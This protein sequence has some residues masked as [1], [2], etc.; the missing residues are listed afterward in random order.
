MWRRLLLPA[1]QRAWCDHAVVGMAPTESSPLRQQLVAVSERLDVVLASVRGLENAELLATLNCPTFSQSLSA[2][3]LEL[4]PLM[5]LPSLPGKVDCFGDGA[6][7]FLTGYTQHLLGRPKAALSCCTAALAAWTEAPA[8]WHYLSAQVA[9]AADNTELAEQC[10]RG[11]IDRDPAH[12]A[13]HLELMGLLA[14]K[15]DFRGC[16]A[17]AGSAAAQTP[18]LHWSSEWQ[19]PDHMMPGLRATPW[20][21]P[22]SFPWVKML[23]ANADVIRSEL[24]TVV[25]AQQAHQRGGKASGGAA[26]AAGQQAPG[27]VPVGHHCVGTDHTL[28]SEGGSWRELVLAGEE[29]EDG[30]VAA[31]N[32]R[33]FPRTTA[34]LAG[35]PAVAGL[36]E[37]GLGEALFSSLAPGSKLKPHCGGSNL[38]LTCHLTLVLGSGESGIICGGEKR[39]WEQGKCLVFDDSFEHAVYHNEPEPAAVAAAEAADHPCNGERVVLLLRFWHPGEPFPSFVL[40]PLTRWHASL[41]RTLSPAAAAPT[42]DTRA[43]A[44]T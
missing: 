34:L 32:R 18:K 24:L 4:Q 40:L 39:T 41:A 37:A 14:D 35:I 17:L 5:G 11:A 3:E 10:L 1:V 13:A 29:D 38:R 6:A 43:R 8:S 22:A 42:I 15:N 36:A 7:R 26:A 25:A 28:V 44:H 23:E 16:R 19:R 12:L 20:H 33:S 2:I 31:A 27:W 21:E 9:L 30:G